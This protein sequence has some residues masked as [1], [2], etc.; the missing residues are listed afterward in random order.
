[1]AARIID[2]KQVAAQMRAELKEQVDRLRAMRVVPGL[3]VILVG[4]D[5]ASASYVTG[6]EKA[7]HDL[8]MYSD[9]N[10]L[11]AETRQEELLA[12]IAKMNADPKI[13][14]ILVQLPL[15]K[16]LDESQ[17][18]LAIDPAKDVDGF[19][20]I[21]VGRMVTGQEAFLPCTP[22]GVVHLLTRSGVRIEG[23]HV[24][25]VGRSNLVGK[26]LAN[27]LIQKGASANATV[28]VCHTK[29]RDMAG[30][31]LRADILIAAAGCPA[32]I[33]ADMVKPG[34]VVIDVG[35]NRVD[36]SSKKAGFRLVG[37]VDFKPVAEKAS[38]ITPVPGGVGPM[39]ITMLL[40]NTVHAAS[41]QSLVRRA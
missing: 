4:D 11:P 24:V 39:T 31:T 38:L 22:H 10:R 36:D 41:A 14:G 18:L 28:T 19:H 21:N 12:L 30:H 35:V 37:D 2:G 9:D 20:P 32:M 16:H 40:Y 5:P 8:G 26:P 13:H 1:M 34:A 25:I 17:V 23:A 15:P 27:M 33:T 7:C 3:G 6:K 29:T